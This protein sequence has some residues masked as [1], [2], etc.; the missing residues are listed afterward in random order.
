MTLLCLLVLLSGCA[1]GRVTTPAGA[2]VEGWAFG[3]SYIEACV[4]PQPA[5]VGPLPKEC[6]TI[7]AST[8]TSLGEILGAAIA[9]AAA[10]FVGPF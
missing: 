8:V 3:N 9:G 10:Y 2:S 4:I 6:A 5:D 1:I 7:K